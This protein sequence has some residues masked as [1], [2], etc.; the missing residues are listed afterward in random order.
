M[1][2]IFIIVSIMSVSVIILVLQGAPLP[3]AGLPAGSAHHTLC[4]C[5][6]PLLELP[7]ALCCV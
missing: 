1:V 6:C 7:G 4:H 3:T 5:L 2:N